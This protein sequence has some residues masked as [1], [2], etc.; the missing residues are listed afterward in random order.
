MFKIRIYETDRKRW[1][2][3]G[4]GPWDTLGGAIEFGQCEIGM[5][6]QVFGWN[7]ELPNGDADREI[8]E[9]L[10]CHAGKHNDAELRELDGS[11]EDIEVGH[12]YCC[13]NELVIGRYA[14]NPKHK[15]F[16]F[17]PDAAVRLALI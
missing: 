15:T 14:Y 3:S 17:V 2:D 6:W 1:H 4:E 5:P 10:V 7:V 16:R 9:E 8:E 13:Q 11:D 12:L